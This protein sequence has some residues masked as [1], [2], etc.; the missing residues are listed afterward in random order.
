MKNLHLTKE[1][2]L[3]LLMKANLS[4]E[5]FLNLIACSKINLFNWIKSNKFPYYVKLILDTAIKVN[6]YKKYEENKPE[7]NQKIDA[8]NILEEIKNLEK[9]NQKLKEEI[10][11]YEKLEELFFEVFGF[12][13]GVRQ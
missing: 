5:Y 13:I 3:N 6:Y 8:K 7:I 4:E 2:F 9:E 12:K 1:E 10:K 11:N